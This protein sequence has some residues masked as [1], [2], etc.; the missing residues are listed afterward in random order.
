MKKRKWKLN[1]PLLHLLIEI[2]FIKIHT[3]LCYRR[4][5]QEV[6][7]YVILYIDVYKWKFQFSLYK[8][9]ND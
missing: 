4:F 7:E 6:F 8:K 3:A 9:E 1:W 2:P 5:E